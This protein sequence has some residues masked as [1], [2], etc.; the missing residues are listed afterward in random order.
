MS[1]AA[2]EAGKHTACTVPMGTSIDELKR[3]IAAKKKSG[4]V[5]MM[6]E[7]AVYTREYLPDFITFFCLILYLYI[8]QRLTILAT[9]DLGDARKNML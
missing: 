1:V 4:K 6:M 8:P 7:T 3:I 9:P 5:Y 2:L